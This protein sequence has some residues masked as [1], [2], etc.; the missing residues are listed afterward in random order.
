MVHEVCKSRSCSSHITHPLPW[1]TMPDHILKSSMTGA[2]DKWHDSVSAKISCREFGRSFM[3]P[4]SARKV[5]VAFYN[6]AA[7]KS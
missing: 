2:F 5:N 1:I 3:R 7:E 4:V 6:A